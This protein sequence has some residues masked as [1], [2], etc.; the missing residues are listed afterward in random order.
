VRRDVDGRLQSFGRLAAALLHRLSLERLREE[1]ALVA[2]ELQIAEA[3]QQRLV[4]QQAPPS[5]AFEF[6]WRS[7]AAKSIGGDYV[8]FLASESGQVSLVVADASG[9]GINSALLMASFRANYRA[10]AGL[11]DVD[12]LAATLNDEVTREVGPTGM[13]VTA[14]L[15]RLDP[16]SRELTLCSAGHNPVL[17]VR[18]GGEEVEPLGSHGTPMGFLGGVAYSRC[19]RSLSTGDLIVIYTDGVTEATR[20]GAEMF[21]EDRLVEVV[22]RHARGTADE[23]LAAVLDAVAAFTGRAAQEDDVSVM[24]VRVR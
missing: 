6:A 16:E 18:A 9:H 14:A 23:V 17:L 22:R 19:E 11:L 3:I 7:V 20:P 12:E 15:A 10:A 13:F 24:V 1:S 21:G 8:D 4:P 2:R 5:S